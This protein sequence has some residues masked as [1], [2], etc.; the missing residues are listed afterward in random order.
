MDEMKELLGQ[1]GKRADS[2]MFYKISLEVCKIK[3]GGA[4]TGDYREHI[5]AGGTIREYHF[6]FTNETVKANMSKVDWQLEKY[7]IKQ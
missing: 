3:R 6:V 2:G 7:P 5:K 4:R 1:C